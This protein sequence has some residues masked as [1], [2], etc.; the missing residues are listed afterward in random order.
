MI[1]KILPQQFQWAPVADATGYAIEFSKA[2]S[3]TNI[4]KMSI[5]ADRTLY[6]GFP[7][8]VGQE[9]P[10]VSLG[11]SSTPVV[12]DPSAPTGKAKY[13]SAPFGTIISKRTRGSQSPALVGE[14]DWYVVARSTEGI[15]IVPSM[16]DYAAGKATY[17]SE[18][19]VDSGAYKEYYVGRFSIPDNADGVEFYLRSGVDEEAGRDIYVDKFILRPSSTSK[20]YWR[21]AAYD[22][23]NNPSYSEAR[24]YIILGRNGHYFEE[25]LA[26]GS[27][28]EPALDP[29]E[30]QPFEGET[31]GGNQWE[32]ASCN[33]QGILSI[34]GELGVGYAHIYL[35]SPGSKVLK[36]KIGYSNNI[37][38][39][40]NGAQIYH[41]ESGSLTP[42]NDNLI[43]ITLFEGWNRLL[44]QMENFENSPGRFF[45]GFYNF[46]GTFPSDIVTALNDP[47]TIKLQNPTIDNIIFSPNGSKNVVNINFTASVSCNVTA[48]I[49]RVSDEE[50]VYNLIENEEFSSG[51]IT[52][53]WDGKDADGNVFE[54]DLYR[55]EIDAVSIINGSNASLNYEV[56]LQASASISSPI[57]SWPIN[58]VML[59]NLL[60]QKFQWEPVADTTGYTIEFSKDSN[61]TNVIMQ[62]SI[63]ADITSYEGSPFGPE[64]EFPAVSLGIS[65]T[66]VVD[67]PSAPTGKAKYAS[68]P[69]GTII[70]KRTRGSQS[71]ALVGEWDWY[72]VAR[73]TEG[74]R[75]VP[76]MHDYAAGK[77]TYASEFYVDSGAYKEYYV[78][79]FSIPDNADGVEFYLRSGDNE[80]AGRDIYVD[81]FIL[82]PSAPKCY[83]RVVA[84]DEVGNASYSE[85]F[86]IL[87]TGSIM[88]S[89]VDNLYVYPNPFVH[90]RDEDIY[91]TFSNGKDSIVSLSIYNLAGQLIRSL[92]KDAIYLDSDDQRIKWDGRDGNG[93]L[94]HSG[95]Y[96]IVIKSK[97]S[98]G[99]KSTTKRIPLVFIR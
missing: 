13:A 94:V 10:A 48:R 24:S 8:G 90:Q 89:A 43:D 30:T 33:E 31:V 45:I 95:L 19:Y 29:S 22:E 47:L 96:L 74:I 5:P 70:S 56:T 44:V 78:G 14:W 54:D 23:Q 51:P 52:I 11:I 37:T 6:E 4:I 66:P 92:I 41:G 72:V 91:I 98:F 83:W 93:R 81:K 17:A 21:V 55:I 32:L 39:Y 38:L 88:Q 25:W 59:S 87:I 9:F 49:V 67:D 18:F 77:A 20:Y 85:I 16:H 7:P 79:R 60:T 76:S 63:P 61:F 12:D 27:F 15:R 75:I 71:P 65:S 57:L 34:P 36:L 2:P 58:G 97:D 69:F 82:R 42:D 73:S 62:E 80:E 40:R 53:T 3:F 84:Y 1:N 64:Q 99:S 28:S 86:E 35:Y 26:L 68:A 46:D 50:V